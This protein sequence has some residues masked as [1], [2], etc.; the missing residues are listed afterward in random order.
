MRKRAL[1]T[2]AIAVASPAYAGGGMPQ[3]DP[4]WFVN[5]FVWLFVS[6]LALYLA[7]SKR[8]VPT[9][10][11]VLATREEAIAGAIREAERARHEAES[12]RGHATS[13]NNVA[14]AKASELI[15]KTQ[16][17]ISAEASESIARLDR[18]LNKRMANVTAV[19]EDAVTKAKAGIDAAAEDLAHTMVAKLTA[20]TDES[21]APKLKLAKS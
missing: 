4:T 3:M 5:G 6:F 14:R 18:D 21:A 7:V 2:A 13:A 15:A 10:A 12:T 11:S 16:A 17:E 9:I 8:I 20:A 19:L 1:L